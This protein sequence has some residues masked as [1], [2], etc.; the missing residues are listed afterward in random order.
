MRLPLLPA[1]LEVDLLSIFDSLKREEE[2][3]RMLVLLELSIWSWKR[4]R[5]IDLNLSN[6]S[7]L[8]SI[9]QRVVSVECPQFNR[10]GSI[11]RISSSDLYQ[12]SIKFFFYS[13]WPI[14]FSKKACSM[15][16]SIVF[17]LANWQQTLPFTLKQFLFFLFLCAP[18]SNQAF[19][20]SK[21]KEAKQ[22]LE[23]VHRASS[24]LAKGWKR[25]D[26]IE[27]DVNKFLKSALRVR[28]KSAGKSASGAK[29][30][31]KASSVPISGSN[32]VSS[33][34][35]I[36]GSKGRKASCP[37]SADKPVCPFFID[38]SPCP[39][40]VEIPSLLPNAICPRGKGLQTVQRV[41]S[42][43]QFS[44]SESGVKKRILGQGSSTVRAHVL[45]A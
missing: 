31:L 3:E 33:L 39:S 38:R 17:L 27:S 19:H 8:P 26:A 18:A 6:P 44:S 32:P 37:I 24:T 13:I 9:V 23:F 7:L 36:G 16:R 1:C 11:S 22:F 2:V 4:G 10:S 20:R 15:G 43:L 5:E 14:L 45:S 12:G 28:E 40:L 25:T 21:G 35:Q 30:G 34:S 41:P 42:K 29:K